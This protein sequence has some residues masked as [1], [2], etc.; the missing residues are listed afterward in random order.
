MSKS[1]TTVYIDSNLK[2]LCQLHGLV[3]SQLLEDKMREV[4]NSKIDL[5]QNIEEVLIKAEYDKAKALMEQHQ[6]ALADIQ[7]RR[8]GEF[9]DKDKELIEAER[10]SMVKI[11]NSRL[12]NKEEVYDDYKDGVRCRNLNKQLSIQLHLDDYRRFCMDKK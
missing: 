8:N 7:Q 9:N 5:K 2:R 6:H 3:L 4:L 1:T 12:K 10:V 11:I